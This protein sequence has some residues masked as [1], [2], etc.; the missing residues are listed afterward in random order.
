MK[1]FFVGENNA[2]SKINGIKHNSYYQGLLQNLYAGNDGE[3]A[4]FLQL[5][6]QSFILS[7]FGSSQA[8]VFAEI[9]EEDLLHAKHLAQAIISLGGDP[10]FCSTQGKWLG[11]RVVD[12]VKGI[13]QMLGINIEAKEK[14]I[15]DYKTTLTKI[16]EIEIKRMIEGILNEEENHLLKLKSVF[17]SLQ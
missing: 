13:K 4:N 2:Y 6:Y 10:I 8:R 17:R 9:A 5:S 16:E 7:P 15:I 11:G 3:M 1:E 14:L 12:Y